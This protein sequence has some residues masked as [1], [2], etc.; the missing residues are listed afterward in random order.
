MFILGLF[1][2]NQSPS[3]SACNNE[4]TWAAKKT[5]SF[6]SFPQNVPSFSL[7]CFLLS[8]SSLVCRAASFALC[9]C[10]LLNL[11]SLLN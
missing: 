2:I 11:I 7:L 4:L 9:L 6:H 5:A 8:L 1:A 10:S 3:N